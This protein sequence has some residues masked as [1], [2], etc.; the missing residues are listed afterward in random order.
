MGRIARNQATAGAADGA[1]Q[2]RTSDD[3]SRLRRLGPSCRHRA[4][5]LGTGGRTDKTVSRTGILKDRS[6]MF[7]RNSLLCL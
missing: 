7:A 1:Q 5:C 2:P 3:A 6:L 4:P